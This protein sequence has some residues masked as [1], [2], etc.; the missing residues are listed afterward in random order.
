MK[1]PLWKSS[2]IDMQVNVV[3]ND[4]IVL[5]QNSCYLLKTFINTCEVYFY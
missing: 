5:K 3:H 1:N 2:L 4:T